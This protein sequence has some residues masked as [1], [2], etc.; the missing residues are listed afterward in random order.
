M[1]ARGDSVDLLDSFARARMD[2]TLAELEASPSV[3]LLR[4]DL[5]EAGCLDR[6]D[7]DYERVVH[8][9]AVVGVAHVLGAPQRTLR[10]NV[11]MTNQVLGWARGLPRLE[12][13]LFASTSEVYAGTLNA[14]DWTIP[15]PED[16]PL[17]VADVA[18][19]RSAY[20]ISKLYG[21]AL[22]HHAEV[23]F[24]IVRPHNVY[25]PRMG[26]SH[27][28]PE[29]LERAHRSPR[30]G[31]LEVYSV[32]HRRTFCFI[33]DA[34]EIILRALDSPE[35]AGETLNVGRGEPEVSIG[36][37]AEL[38]IETVGKPLTVHALPPTPGSPL[39]R[40]PDMAKTVRLTGWSGRTE[41]RDGLRRTYDWYRLRIFDGPAV[42]VR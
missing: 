8:L 14:F 16:V 33:D 9:A 2:E 34:V 13:L 40:C 4:L 24:T 15:T 5:L 39:R 18:D 12:R 37:L 38:V 41:L 17:T 7:R 30:N 6:L 27:V 21:E 31:R 19:A 11:T 42:D 32:D 28:I 23:P 22:C 20:A 1:V 10:D 26:L 25:G 35:C 36:R 3:R 29:L